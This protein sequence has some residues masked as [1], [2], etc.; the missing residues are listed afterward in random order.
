MILLFEDVIEKKSNVIF[1]I[2]KFNEQKKITLPTLHY[3]S[4]CDKYLYARIWTP[5]GI[6]P[7]Y[8]RTIRYDLSDPLNPRLDKNFNER[9]FVACHNMYF[10]K[11]KNNIIRSIG[12]Q[13]R[14]NNSRENF[15]FNREFSAYH[16]KSKMLCNPSIM[17]STIIKSYF[18]L[19]Y[20]YTSPCPYYANG[21]HLFNLENTNLICQ[22]KDLPIITGLHP[23]RTDGFY[24]DFDDNYKDINKSKGG[25]SVFDSLSS[26]IYD[27]ANDLYI[28]Y[29]RANISRG[30]RSIQYCTSKDLINWSPFNL[31]NLGNRYNHLDNNVYYSNFYKL[32]KTN[33]TIGIL[34][35]INPNGRDPFVGVSQP[36]NTSQ[37]KI[38]HLNAP[39][40]ENTKS[41]IQR[42]SPNKQNLL[43]LKLHAANRTTKIARSVNK[44]SKTI[45]K[46]GKKIVIKREI[47]PIVKNPKLNNM[48]Y[49]NNFSL[50]YSFDSINFKYI[51][52]FLSLPSTGHPYSLSANHPYEHNDKL[53][54][55]FYYNEKLTVYT[56][57]K[58]R[59][60]MATNE[61]NNQ[62]S[63]FTT[64]LIKFND[65]KILLNFTMM[66]NGYI[67]VQLLDNS[68][69][70]I[71][72]FSFND[73]EQI[74]NL[75]SF[76]QELSW[77]KISE[78]PIDK[79]KL[80][81]K[82]N[83]AQIYSINGMFE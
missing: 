65:K 50:V 56:L 18:R 21:L 63:N 17:K 66:N 67:K 51:G 3:M 53:H 58:N 1:N 48:A 44:N 49:L 14:G 38:N 74:S 68:N 36:L 72:G 28:L 33:F 62:E 25:L 7:D 40:P 59:Y 16:T 82:F 39:P 57:E 13:H 42:T 4:I 70:I 37:I 45:T 32:D 30:R 55:Y 71:P 76:N 15:M 81:V 78:I 5:K 27:S 35:F 22:N 31:I 9:K 19:I 20:D 47:K 11:D 26:V 43:L 73:F 10:F 6:N 79:V 64:K 2:C 77:N 80:E 54:F 60:T 29:Q 24:G 83:N 8:E 69:N 41:N 75:N 46:I 61:K 34:P 23:G 52:D 12:G